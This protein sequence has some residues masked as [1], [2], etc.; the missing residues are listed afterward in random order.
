MYVFFQPELSAGFFLGVQALHNFF[1]TDLLYKC[2]KKGLKFL[3]PVLKIGECVYKPRY[4]EKS[5]HE[6]CHEKTVHIYA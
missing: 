6:R 2:V 5:S 4:K 1:F 3:K